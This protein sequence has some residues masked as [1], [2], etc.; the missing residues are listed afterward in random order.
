ML[1]Y[2]CNISY[3]LRCFRCGTKT[4]SMRVIYYYMKVG[5]KQQTEYLCEDC[6]SLRQAKQAAYRDFPICAVAPELL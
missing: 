2:F 3:F 6:Y 1:S 4:L 5:D